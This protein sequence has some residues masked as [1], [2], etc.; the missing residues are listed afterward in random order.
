MMGDAYKL[1]DWYGRPFKGHSDA[2]EEDSEDDDSDEGDEEDE[3]PERDQDGNGQ[4]IKQQKV[5]QKQK[6][7]NRNGD[8]E[9]SKKKKLADGMPH[10]PSAGQI[11][12]M[13]IMQ[14][15]ATINTIME[16]V[17]AQLLFSYLH[18]CRLYYS[19]F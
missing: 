17:D 14:A 9:A 10:N 11:D 4:V 5:L 16:L 13:R 1:A 7:G 3:D 19:S 8:L 6:A 15:K 2:E 12:V 18:I